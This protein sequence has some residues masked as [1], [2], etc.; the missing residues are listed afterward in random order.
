MQ[1]ARLY[2]LAETAQSSI[3]D[4]DAVPVPGSACARGGHGTVG[5]ACRRWGLGIFIVLTLHGGRCQARFVK[6][7]GLVS[8]M[9][10]DALH[11]SGKRRR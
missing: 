3:W 6:A 1:A 4:G 11:A 9:S 10:S 8:L 2:R 5:L 7:G